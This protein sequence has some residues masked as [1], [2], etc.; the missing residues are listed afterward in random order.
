MRVPISRTFSWIRSPLMSTSSTSP[1][2][3]VI[4]VIFT[5][6]SH[7]QPQR[8]LRRP[9]HLVVLGELAREDP[10]NPPGA[11][12]H[13][14]RPPPE[15]PGHLAVHQRPHDLFRAP[16]AQRA[17]TIPLARHPH[18]VW[19]ESGIEICHLGPG[20]VSGIETVRLSHPDEPA[21]V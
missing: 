14:R 15:V 1:I 3:L 2:M 18:P 5:S 16:E 19:P 9:A 21:R 4:S 17:N 20:S 6:P 12:H 7:L 11:V 13:H 10:G 8:P